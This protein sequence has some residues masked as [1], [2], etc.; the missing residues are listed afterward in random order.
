MSVS[1]DVA[2]GS[3]GRRPYFT[4]FDPSKLNPGSQQNKPPTSCTVIFAATTAGEMLP[5]HFQLC[6]KA[7]NDDGLSRSVM[8]SFKNFY[9]VIVQAIFKKDTELPVTFGKNEKGGTTMEEFEKYI[10][11]SIVP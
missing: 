11:D 8:P 3:P 1:V 7:K 9:N 4:F 10:M 2:S 5:P 6:T